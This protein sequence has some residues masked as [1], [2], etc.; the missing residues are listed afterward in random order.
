MFALPWTIPFKI[1]SD[2]KYFRLVH[3]NQMK[4]CSECLSP[5]HM[6]KQCPYFVC[7]GCGEYG[8]SKRQCKAIK[9]EYC[10]NLPLLCVCGSS[11]DTKRDQPPAHKKKKNCEVCNFYFC[12]CKCNICGKKECI[13][14]CFKCEKYPCICTC[15]FCKSDPCVCPCQ[16]CRKYPCVCTCDTCTEKLH[17]CTC[18]KQNDENDPEIVKITGE[19]DDEDISDVW[20]E[21]DVGDADPIAT[22]PIEVNVVQ[23]KQKS[24][25]Q[26]ENRKR[27]MDS[28]TESNNEITDD[29]ILNLDNEE[30]G[31]ENINSDKDFSDGKKLKI[32]SN[33]APPGDNIVAGESE[34]EIEFEQCCSDDESTFVGDEEVSMEGANENESSF[35]SDGEN[36]TPNKF[37]SAK[38]ARKIKKK[39]R[40]LERRSSIKCT[41]NLNGKHYTEKLDNLIIGGDFN[42]SLSMLDRGGKSNHV[43]DEPCKKLID[44]IENN[45]FKATGA[46]INKQ[47][48][49][50]LCVGYGELS[51]VETE[52]F[53]LQV[54]KDAI[55]LLGVYVGPNKSLCDDMNWKN[56]IKQVRSLLNMWLQ[57]QLT[58]Q[59]RV[60]VVNTLMLS[61]FWYTLFVTSMPEWAYVEIKRLCV[62]FIWDNRSHLVKYS[63]IVGEKC[64]GGLQL[65]DIKCKMYA[66]R[67]KYIGRL[68]DD[69]YHV[70][71]KDI[72]KY[73][74]SKIYGM[75]LG[76]EILYT[77]IPNCELKC[78]P[79]VYQEMCQALYSLGCK[80][81]FQ[82]TVENIYD[83]P[84]FCNPNIVLYDKTIIWYDFIRAGIVTI[85]DIL[86]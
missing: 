70:L 79:M 15:A 36:D 58:L 13:C 71:W 29:E 6:R 2:T 33:D 38:M 68:I 64:K 19:N 46:K 30:G 8:H 49:E 23:T 28:D 74:V 67:L 31:H 56:K 14:A 4:V 35:C 16:D 52:Q 80:I 47:K 39:Q 60:T 85:K 65:S 73:F 77:T 78:I 27:K 45:N 43:I 37:I 41:P 18:N 44:L 32:A 42:T 54:C 7:H 40:R 10:H 1:G 55:Q 11:S 66:F 24:H 48:S 57:R 63:S 61:R 86:L 34:N 5:E 50:I 20:S 25:L 3:N 69:Q 82:L 26:E 84:L 72:F 51:D 21:K 83:Q 12:M 81:D 75:Q 9:C 17:R 59:G 22:V 62:N 53:G 76:L